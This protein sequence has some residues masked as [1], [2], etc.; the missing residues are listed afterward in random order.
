MK[1]LTI[2][3]DIWWISYGKQMENWWQPIWKMTT[4]YDKTNGNLIVII[5][6]GNQ[7]THIIEHCNHRPVTDLQL[8]VAASFSRVYTIFIIGI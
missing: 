8:H 5:P 4:F 7:K 3:S 2:I 1:I 6:G